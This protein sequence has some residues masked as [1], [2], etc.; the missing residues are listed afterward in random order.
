MSLRHS[1]PLLF[2][3]LSGRLPP[4]V[5]RQIWRFLR[6]GKPQ[7]LH[8]LTGLTQAGVT[9]TMIVGGHDP[10]EEFLPNRFFVE[11]PACI[12][13][14][15]VSVF[16]LP[17]R[18]SELRNTADVIAFKIDHVLIKA[19]FN[20][21]YL[22]VPEWI[23]SSMTIPD[24]FN[25]MTLSNS[26]RQDLRL[27]RKN[28]LGFVESQAA[29][30]LVEFFEKFYRPHGLGRHGAS[31]QLRSLASLRHAMKRG[32][33]LWI[34]DAGQR[35]AG[36]LLEFNQGRMLL[37]ALGTVGGDEALMKK[38][39]LAA[40]YHFSLQCAQARGCAIMDF[41]GT[42]PAL[43][44]GLLR[45]KRK[46]GA[47]IDPKPM[48][49]FDTLVGWSNLNPSVEAMLRSTPLVIRDRGALSVL[50]LNS[51]PPLEPEHLRGLRRVC[52]VGAGATWSR[53]KGT[54]TGE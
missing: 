14:G 44:D 13:L 11:K 23:R 35:V 4:A 54:F 2:G 50:Q 19:L 9:G 38:G 34:M 15:N 53:A 46:W 47:V 17:R 20:T 3:R 45:Y 22:R 8:R 48:N 51:A 52:F 12:S 32:V 7:P 36:V 31:A 43:N 37:V 10:W 6:M 28:G 41:G 18:L 42:R 27:I 26:L 25:N 29:A 40:V 39:A 33:L 16:Q 5:D 1:I 30:D 24:V 49:T 21:D